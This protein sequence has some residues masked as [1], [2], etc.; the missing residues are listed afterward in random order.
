MSGQAVH[1][2]F[3]EGLTLDNLLNDWAQ[4]LPIAMPESIRSQLAVW[5]QAYGQVR[6]YEKVTLIEFSDDYTLTEMKAVTS[7][8]QRLIAEISSRLVLIPQEAV[9]PLVI[10]LEQAG[11]TPKQT[12]GV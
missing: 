12:N 9:E 1:A 3:E 4:L 6:I 5:W 2:A 10:E 7:L 8:E 11:F